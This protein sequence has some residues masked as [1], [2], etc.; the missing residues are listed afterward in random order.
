MKR[1]NISILEESLSKLCDVFYHMEMLFL[2]DKYIHI[3]FHK[4]N[5]LVDQFTEDLSLFKPR[6]VDESKKKDNILRE[7]LYHSY[8]I[9]S[10]SD[11]LAFLK[12]HL[13]SELKTA[14]DA[15]SKYDDIKPELVKKENRIIID[16]DRKKSHD[17]LIDASREYYK[18]PD[19]ERHLNKVFI[20][21]SKLDALNEFNRKV[22][23]TGAQ[24]NSIINFR[25]D[26][27]VDKFHS[28]LLKYEHIIPIPVEYFRDIINGQSIFKITFLKSKSDLASI[29]STLFENDIVG[30]T[31]RT[32]YVKFERIFVD[33]NGTPLVDLSSASITKNPELAEYITA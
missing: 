19:Y 31:K 10:E 3:D 6:T 13:E 15:H 17:T 18:Y 23:Y 7:L 2:K 21:L 9:R 16:P 11:Y 4:L 22:L 29:V 1:V 28:F 20:T 27:Y 14:K 12:S 33:Q 32:P 8:A 26:Q 25:T 30:T 5:K 24:P